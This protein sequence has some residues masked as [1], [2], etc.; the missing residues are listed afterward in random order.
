MHNP[1]GKDHF[2]CHNL[3]GLHQKALIADAPGRGKNTSFWLK[4]AG[5]T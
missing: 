3:G 4:P 1:Q 5:E 2:W